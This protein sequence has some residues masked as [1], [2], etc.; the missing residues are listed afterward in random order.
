MEPTSAYEQAAINLAVAESGSGDDWSCVTSE[1]DGGVEVRLKCSG[2]GVQGLYV[3][4]NTTLEAFLNYER[5][6]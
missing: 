2:E 3:Y 4:S 5:L 1:T 6:C